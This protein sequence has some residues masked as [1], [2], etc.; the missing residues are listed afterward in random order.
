MRVVAESIANHSPA[1]GATVIGFGFRAA[2]WPDPPNREMLDAVSGDIPVVLISADLH[3]A[4]L[5]TAALRRF[6]H[7]DHA[8]GLLREDDAM[9]V[10]GESGNAGDEDH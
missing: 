5:N 7:D 8:S 10:I 3:S 9:H 1:Q 4:W 2:L 6:G